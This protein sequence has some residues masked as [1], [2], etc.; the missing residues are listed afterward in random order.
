MTKME[1][2]SRTARGEPT[3]SGSY[4]IDREER[5]AI[6]HI[7]RALAAHLDGVA[8]A[9]GDEHIEGL[10]LAHMRALWAMEEMRTRKYVRVNTQSD[11]A[12]RGWTVNYSVGVPFVG[13]SAS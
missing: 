5:K 8:T 11:R 6:R 10:S 4:C 9:F 13:V 12:V 2:T 1:I 7:E 3:W